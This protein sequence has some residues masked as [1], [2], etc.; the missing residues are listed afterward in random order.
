MM[1]FSTKPLTK[2]KN[3]CKE[4][5]LASSSP[6]RKEI[7]TA[8]GLKFKV[9]PSHVDEGHNGLTKTDEIVSH[10]AYKKAYE[11][12]IKN[13]GEWVIGSDTLVLLSNGKISEKPIDRADAK[14]TILSY[15]GSHCDVYSG[16]TLIKE[17]EGSVIEHTGYEKTRIH[18]DKLTNEQIEE[19][20]DSEEWQNRSGSMTIEGRGGRWINNIDGCYWNVVGLP[21]NLLKEFILE[22][23]EK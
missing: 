6:Q 17:T 11:I 14:E 19:Y 5:I 15:S 23:G 2:L 16:L 4:F 8:L 21:V 22:S 7:L 20:L 12:A 1:K 18:F 3:E 13:P 10:L 9:I